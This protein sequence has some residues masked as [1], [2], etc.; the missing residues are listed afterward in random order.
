MSL[1]VMWR[2]DE[3]PYWSHNDTWSNEFTAANGNELTEDEFEEYHRWSRKTQVGD[4]IGADDEFVHIRLETPGVGGQRVV[5]YPHEIAHEAG[6]DPKVNYRQ[7]LADVGVQIT[8]TPGGWK[9][10]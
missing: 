5:W 9:L 1:R 6:Y 10:G 7:K 2:P 3:T 4:I 8:D